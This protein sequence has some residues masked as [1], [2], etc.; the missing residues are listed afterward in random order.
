VLAVHFAAKDHALYPTLL[1]D[2]RTDV[3][4]LAK[5]FKRDMAGLKKSFL[6]Y[7]KRWSRDAIQE[8]AYSFA[9]ETNKILPV[10]V[11]RFA[12]EERDF[13]PVAGI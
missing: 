6:E 5:K 9:Q 3:S 2:S 8:H 1:S 12:H 7:A 11:E 4:A 13:Y 10:L